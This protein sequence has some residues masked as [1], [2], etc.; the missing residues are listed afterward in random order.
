MNFIL[1]LTVCKQITLAWGYEVTKDN[2]VFK[3][4]EGRGEILVGLFYGLNKDC[5]VCVKNSC[6]CC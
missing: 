6:C 1:C 4:G 3:I 5:I 2:I